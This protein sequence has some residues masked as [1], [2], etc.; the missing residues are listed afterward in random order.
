M[1][2]LLCVVF[3]FLPVI[4]TASAQRAPDA[5]PNIVV[6]VADDAG[7]DFGCYGNPNIQ[8]TSIDK[9]A[10]NGLLCSKAFLTSPQCSPSRT[11]M[12]AGKFAHTIGTEDLHVGIENDSVKTL[13]AYLGEAGYFTG[14]ML[15]GHFGK[16]AA[17][18]FNWTDNGFFPDYVEGRWN[19]KALDNFKGFL[20]A[21]GEKP[22]FLWMAF[23]DPHRPYR[24]KANAAP[25]VNKPGQV[26]VPPYLVD[27]PETRQDLADYYDEITRMDTHIGLMA[28][29]LEK[30]GLDGNTLTV[31]L[32]DN[33]MPFPRAKGSLYDSGIKTPLVFVWPG[34]TRPGT[35][36]DG[37]LST[38]D[39]TATLLD[40]AGLNTPTDWYGKSFLGLLNGSASYTPRPYVFAER[41][42]HGADEYMRCVSDG[43][44]KLI[45]NAYWHLPFGTPNEILKS[46]SWQ[47]VIHA[48][49][50]GG[51]GQNHWQHYLTPRPALEFYDTANDPYELNNL[52]TDPA[53]FHLMEDM[54]KVM[55]AWQKETAD[56]YPHQ[57]Q[58][59]DVHDRFT[60]VLF[61]TDRGPYW[62]SE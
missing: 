61:R 50:T 48:K 54:S 6:F 3:G 14:F 53:Y 37:L 55:E 44:F 58:R 23:V 39:L 60:G 24:D 56:H 62:G 10:K 18:Q 25:E 38:V 45:Y 26:L 52:G 20:D 15:K 31:F 7:M 27:T 51:L 47:A 12:L 1:K 57:R 49:K 22:F 9:M 35:Q 21:A 28:A 36:Y 33:G 17:Q 16:G 34:K 30:R 40:A 42:W 5:R 8:T 59:L 41:N 19:D 13:P 2:V 29:E 11:S 46:P 32:S 4:R 43:R